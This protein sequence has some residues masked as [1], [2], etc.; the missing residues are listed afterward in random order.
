M[1]SILKYLKLDKYLVGTK[2]QSTFTEKNIDSTKKKNL[3]KQ[4]HKRLKLIEKEFEK[5]T[6][7]NVPKMQVRK[8]TYRA[9]LNVVNLR[10]QN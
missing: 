8:K 6:R 9:Y 4:L 3:K 2:F 10:V 7:K 1:L 5:L